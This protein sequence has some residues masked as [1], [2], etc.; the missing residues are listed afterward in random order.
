M[1]YADSTAL[2]AYLD[3]TGSTK[4]SLLASLLVRAQAMIDTHCGR[5][6]EAASDTT[7]YFDAMR[8]VDGRMLW[9]RDDLATIT[10]V[11]NGDGVAVS[12]SDYVTEP[13]NAGPYYAICLKRGASVAWTYDDS[14]ENAIE[15][16][17]KWAYS[18][19]A[20]A[21]ITQATVRLAAYLFRQAANNADLDRAVV[22]GNVTL[23][24]TNLPRDL[25]MMLEPYVRRV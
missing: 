13:R 1:A 11:T 21:D 19:T 6:F 24:P 2:K 3:I 9:L 23:L 20:P 17:G 8:D 16:V 12:A 7:R 14:P 5:T 10:S 4:D 25:A 15:V 18:A 22:A